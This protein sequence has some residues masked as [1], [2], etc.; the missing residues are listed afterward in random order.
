MRLAYSSRKT[1]LQHGNWSRSYEQLSQGIQQKIARLDE[2]DR[3]VDKL[4]VDLPDSPALVEWVY[5]AASRKL[6]ITIL[7]PRLTEADKQLRLQHFGPDAVV[8]W[9]REKE[10]V[11]GSIAG[12]Y[13]HAA[14]VL[15]LQP[16]PSMK[17]ERSAHPVK[18]AKTDENEKIEKPAESANQSE[19][20][21]ES[22]QERPVWETQRDGGMVLFSSGSTGMPKSILRPLKAMERELQ[23]YTAEPGAPDADSRVLCLVPLSHSYGLLSATLSTLLQGGTVYFPERLHPGQIAEQI[24]KDRLTHVYGVAFHYQLLAK[25]L[26]ERSPDDRQADAISNLKLLSSGGKLP[27]ALITEYEEKFGWRIG[28]QYGMSEVG[29]MAV[30]FYGEGAGTVGPVARHHQISTREGELVIHLP[31][32]PYMEPQPN[33]EPGES[34]DQQGVLYTQDLVQ[35]DDMDRLIIAGRVNDQVSVGGLK[36]RLS[37]IEAA[38]CSHPLVAQSCV[39]STEHAVFGTVLTLFVVWEE[40]CERPMERQLKDWLASRLASYKVPKRIQTTA[41]IPVSPAGKIIKAELL[42]E[43]KDGTEY[44]NQRTRHA[45]QSV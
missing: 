15:S 14:D 19:R 25:G 37:E 6:T 42:K 29:Y 39:V 28:Q 13:P 5:A 7:D 17:S 21:V 9:Q 4:A 2:L 16:V 34:D 31:S 20:A 41:R 22:S 10:A 1:A 38:A 32:S 45:G 44:A 8:S 30:D 33:W 23:V 3:R 40:A 36:V 12:F 27:D 35:F 43:L 24:D 18:S 11:A 26:P